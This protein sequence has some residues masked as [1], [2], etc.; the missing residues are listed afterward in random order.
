MTQDVWACE[1]LF[2]DGRPARVSGP[3]VPS[4]RCRC[5]FLRCACRPSRQVPRTGRSCCCCTASRSHRR[6]GARCCPCSAT[7]ASGPWRRTCGAMGA[8]TG[9]SPGMTST[10]WRGTSSNWPA[11]FSQTA[12]RTWWGMTGEASSP[13]TWPPGTP[14]PWTGWWPSTRPTWR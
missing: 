6:A 10:R 4:P 7:R 3:W 11:T 14:R 8:R 5:R 9:R 1:A 12:P 2:R 13:F